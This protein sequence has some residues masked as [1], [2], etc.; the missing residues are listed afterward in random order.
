MKAT[1]YLEEKMHRDTVQD[2]LANIAKELEFK[3]HPYLFRHT[4]CTRLLKK[5][6]DLTIDSRLA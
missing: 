2:W 5:D 1:I 6:V 3:L 4:F